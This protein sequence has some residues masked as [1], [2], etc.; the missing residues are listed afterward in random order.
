M[1]A[2]G[3]S[4]KSVF[5]SFFRFFDILR[6]LFLNLLFWGLVIAAA[7]L[8]FRSSYSPEIS[9]NSVLVIRP[10]GIIVEHTSSGARQLMS[11]VS[12]EDQ[13]TPL[14]MILS[15]LEEASEDIKIS[16]VFLDLRFFRGSGLSKLQEAG[17]ALDKVK[18]AGKTVIAFSDNYSQGSY[19][20]ASRADTIVM[21]PLGELMFTGLG[22]FRNYFGK[23]FKKYGIGVNVFKTGDYKNAVEPYTSEGMSFFAREAVTD[24]LGDLWAGY[25]A[26]VTEGRKIKKR[27]LEK[28]ITDYAAVL[29][30]HK[31]DSAEAARA[32]KLVDEIAVYEDARKMAGEGDDV[33]WQDYYKLSGRKEKSAGSR[34]A[35]V[36][37]SGTIMSGTLPSGVIGSSSYSKILEK[38][39]DD[40]RIKAV[41]LRIDSGGG[42]VA[43]SE[44]IRRS[45]QK[46]RESGKSVV[47]S[48]SSTAAS[49]AYWI[50]TA[51]DAILCMPATLT[52]S[53]G[54]FAMMPD[55]SVFLEKYPGITTDGYGTTEYV[56]FYRPEISMTD[57]MKKV[58]QLRIE[59]DYSL[60]LSLVSESRKITEKEA[61]KYAGG[62]V[63]SG[64][65]AVKNNLADKTGT[66]SDAVMLAWEKYREAAG[67]TESTDDDTSDEFTVEYFEPEEDWRLS[68]F[69]EFSQITGR[70]EGESSVLIRILD[71]ILKPEAALSEGGFED[72]YRDIQALYPGGGI[73]VR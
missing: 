40:E 42:G 17:Y 3:D 11:D 59:N 69:R 23:G 19:Y 25:L 20:L 49:G 30:K 4:L 16:S 70:T 12:E 34:I 54:V 48:M 58:M 8:Y 9:D 35:V 57:D 60:F 47:V 6:K 64:T 55:L 29:G 65:D 44:Q 32:G 5:S 15:V 71:K 31:G 67:I 1:P 61:R 51:S 33:D 66:L 37:A 39:R 68:L 73:I 7:V 50:A 52:G 13:D 56:N 22:D 10:A 72:N 53:I 2:G 18:A 62:R 43:A 24:F 36:I 21:D 63:W 46:V 28:Y 38:I 14:R 41:V 27:D 26:D 45:L